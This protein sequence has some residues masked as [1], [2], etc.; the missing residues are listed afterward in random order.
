M[1]RAE[2]EAPSKASVSSKRVMGGNLAASRGELKSS[3]HSV[4]SLVLDKHAGLVDKAGHGPAPALPG[5]LRPQGPRAGPHP[6]LR[7]G[8]PRQRHRDGGHPA[9]QPP[10]TG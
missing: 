8:I 10:E 9:P 4:P 5:D 2:R 3:S 1:A 6:A 7:L